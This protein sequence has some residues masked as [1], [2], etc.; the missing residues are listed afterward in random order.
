VAR[1]HTNIHRATTLNAAALVRLLERCDA[2][3][4]PQ[5][6]TDA[7][8]ACELDARGRLG[9]EDRDYPSRRLLTQA[10]DTAASLPTAEVAA[11]AIARG[12]QGDA[13][14]KAIHQARVQ[15]VAAALHGLI[16]SA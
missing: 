16:C 15:A 10:F 12:A 4:R 7:L 1:E 14:A 6:F 5:R 2:F 13:I 3:R 8:L 9:L 11:T